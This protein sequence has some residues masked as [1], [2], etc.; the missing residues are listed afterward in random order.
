MQRADE[1]AAPPGA[2]A[3]G[4][5]RAPCSSLGQPGSPSPLS[6]LTFAWV[7]PLLWHGSTQEQLHQRDLFELPAELHPAA[8][9]HRLLTCWRREV[10]PRP[11]MLYPPACMAGT[12]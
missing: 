9:G 2:A 10:G 7:V 8:C 6:S 5:A 1:C 4:A 12:L 3:A 11:A